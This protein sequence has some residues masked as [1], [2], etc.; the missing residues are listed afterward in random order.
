MSWTLTAKTLKLQA[1]TVAAYALAAAA[2]SVM[3]VVLFERVI[4]RHIGFVQQYVG[5][6]PKGLLRLFNVGGGFTTF[7]GFVGAEYLSFVWVVLVAAF[8]IAFTSGALARELEQGTLELLLAYPIG[9]LRVF[10]SK[11]AAALVGL[12]IITAATVLGIWLGAVSQH[13]PVTWSALGSV[14]LLCVAFGVAITG[15]G[16]LFSAAASERAV[17]AGGAA[18]LTVVFYAMNFASQSWDQLAGLSHITLFTYYQPQDAIDLGRVDGQAAAVLVAV[19]LA[20]ALLGAAIF[21][22]R[23]LSP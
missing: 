15:Y 1:G 23:D 6:F 20:G 17:A 10:A 2:Y 5:L 9:R 18:A 22:W 19:G 3:V 21:R 8:A 11:V 12:V 13:A 4:A 16:F 7:G 14:G